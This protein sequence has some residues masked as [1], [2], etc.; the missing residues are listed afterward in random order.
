MIACLCVILGWSC[1]TSGARR[2]LIFCNHSRPCNTNDGAKEQHACKPQIRF[3]HLMLIG[4]PPRQ[5]RRRQAFLSTWRRQCGRY[6]P[7]LPGCQLSKF[8]PVNFRLAVKGSMQELVLLQPCCPFPDFR[9]HIDISPNLCRF[10]RLTEQV[11][12]V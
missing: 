8:K 7:R 6:R 9:L 3:I 10:I 1:G 4:Q 12:R 11:K 2:C 5:K